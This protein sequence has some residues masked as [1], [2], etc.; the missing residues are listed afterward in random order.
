MTTSEHSVEKVLG[1]A[2]H[3]MPPRDPKSLAAAIVGVATGGPALLPP[4]R[5]E[6]DADVEGVLA[7][8][9]RVLAGT[10]A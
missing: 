1:G 3:L 9:D 10:T 8:Y 2:V 5:Y 6:I 7:V 4:A